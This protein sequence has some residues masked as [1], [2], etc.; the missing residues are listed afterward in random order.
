MR[1]RPKLV[2][3]ATTAVLALAACGSGFSDS[4]APATQ[5]T[6]PAALN[7]LVAGDP[8][9]TAAV[10]AAAQKWA[11]ATGNTVTVNP[12]NDMD[13]QLSQGFASGNPPDLFMVDSGRFQQYAKAGNLLAY[14]DTLPYRNDIYPTLNKTFTYQNKLYCPAKD[15][16]TLGLEINTDKWAAAGLTAADIP[17][18]WQQLQTVASKLSTGGTTGL[19]FNDTRDRIGAFMKQAGGWVTN[20]DQTQATAAS[21]QNVE[22]LKYVQGLLSSGAAKYPKQIGAGDAIE[23]FGQGKAAMIIEGNWFLGGMQADYPTVK[24]TVAPLPAGPAGA[25]TLSFT[26]CWGIAA[27]STFQEQAKSLVNALMTPAQQIDFA[28]VFGVMPSLQSARA[29]YQKDFPQFAPF[30][31]AADSAQGP[32]TLPGITPVLLQFDTGLQGLP[33]ADPAK[34][35]DELQRNTAA[36]IS[37]S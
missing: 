22:A 4:A 16:S 30:L 14:G 35:L 11:T 19:V 37:G 13:Q 8:S 34:I 17:K 31:A 36:V 32:V 26:Q 28:Q 15:F 33:G 23:A 2:A 6:G 21:P 29:T 27:Q 10:N 12:A 1:S 24:Y 18:N 9:D 25:G 7:V 20:A 5:R 3:A